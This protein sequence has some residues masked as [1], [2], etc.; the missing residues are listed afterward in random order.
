MKSILFTLII[1]MFIGC[2]DI[3]R[4]SES[5]N[6]RLEL[7]P[8]PDKA[9]R[10]EYEK[11]AG[12]EIPDTVRRNCSAL[13]LMNLKNLQAEFFSQLDSILR[14]QYPNNDREPESF[15]DLTPRLLDQFLSDIN[16]DSLILNGEFEKEYHFNLAP[17]GFTDPKICKDKISITFDGDH[18]GFRLV[19]YN[20][21]LVEP[22]WCTENNVVYG[23]EIR[24]GRII[25]FGRQEA[26]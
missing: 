23:F 12:S 6:D 5:H 17:P 14:V 15:V 19:I 18:C 1:L 3:Q 7:V 8:E 22:S 26:G 21:F 11:S 24:D 20:T 13:D 4:N 2:N 16:K 25:D 9:L 10:L